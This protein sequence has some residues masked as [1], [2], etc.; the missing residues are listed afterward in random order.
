MTTCLHR[1]ACPPA[2]SPDREAARVV[3]AHPAI[4][5]TLL[6]NGVT[7]LDDPDDLLLPDEVAAAA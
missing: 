2:S 7:I 6:C 1:P 4:G 5:W 3:A